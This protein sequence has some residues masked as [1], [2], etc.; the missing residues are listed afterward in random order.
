VALN[1]IDAM[2]EELRLLQE[3]VA[4]HEERIAMLEREAVT[5]PAAPVPKRIS[6]AD[7]F[8]A[9][10]VTDILEEGKKT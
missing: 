8:K 3:K 6:S 5:A 7:K 4:R 9:V 1:A 10:K 2:R